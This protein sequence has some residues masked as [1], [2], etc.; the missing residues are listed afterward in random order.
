MSAIWL[1]IVGSVGVA[2]AFV[3]PGRP[4]LNRDRG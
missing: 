1:Y 3:G 4:R 2:V